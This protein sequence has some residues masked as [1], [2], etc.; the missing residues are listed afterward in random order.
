MFNKKKKT[1]FLQI[2]NKF[3]YRLIYKIIFLKLYDQYFFSKH[4][5]IFLE[6]K[7][8]KPFLNFY[9]I[10]VFI[11]ETIK[12]QPFENVFCAK[13]VSLTV[14]QISKRFIKYIF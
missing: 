9:Y 2:F 7:V 5:L 14:F 10:F 8:V 4:T 12:W 3:Y 6:Y 11:R 13:K 1:I